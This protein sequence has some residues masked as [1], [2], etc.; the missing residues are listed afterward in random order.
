MDKVHIRTYYNHQPRNVAMDET[1]TKIKT[2]K[3]QIAR[4][5]L[6]EDQQL[7]KLNLR[8]NA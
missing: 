2:Q 3:L 4:W 7:M 1:S 8:I 6:T 5:V